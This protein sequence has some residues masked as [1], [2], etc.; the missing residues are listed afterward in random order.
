MIRLIAIL[1][2]ALALAGCISFNTLNLTVNDY[3]TTSTSKP[4]G[5]P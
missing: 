1:A 3:R 2:V 5:R 4:E